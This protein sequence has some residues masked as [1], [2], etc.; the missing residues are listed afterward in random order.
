METFNIT[1]SNKNIPIPSKNEYRLKLIMKMEKLLK[2][3][4]WKAL[5]F[6]GKLKVVKK[7]I[8]VLK[9]VITIKQ[10]Q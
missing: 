7:K 9:N 8:L 3:M 6:I 1:Y 10:K 4:C 2:R 5:A